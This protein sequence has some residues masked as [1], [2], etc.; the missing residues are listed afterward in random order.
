DLLAFL[1]ETLRAPLLILCISRPELV[2][3]R[4]GWSRHGGS[5]HKLIEL[6]P[7]S[8]ADAA[9]VMHDLLAPC[10]EDEAVEDLVD[11]ACTLAGG[12]PALLERMVRIFL[13]MGFL[14]NVDEFAQ[15]A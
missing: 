4:D 2:A 6:T 14:E 5:R 8:D 7:L 1:I 10:G 11:A 15:A 12:N 9:G 3:R 13:D